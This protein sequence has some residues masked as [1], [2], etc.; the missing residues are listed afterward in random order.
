M[1]KTE[2]L[3]AGLGAVAGM[4]T[5][6]APAALSHVLSKNPSKKLEHSKLSFIQSPTVSKLTK[7]LSLLEMGADKMPGTPARITTQQA[8]ARVISGAFVGATVYKANKGSLLKGLLIGGTAALASTYAM[9]YLRKSLTNIPYIK[10]PMLGALED[11]L[12]VKLAMSL[13]RNKL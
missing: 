13:V 3:I 6:I 4:R 7:F 2:K 12:S 9:Y 5:N 1:N 10:D 11:L 8:M